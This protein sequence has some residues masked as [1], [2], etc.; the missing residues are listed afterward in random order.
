MLHYN[1]SWLGGSRPGPLQP[2]G[3]TG[4]GEQESRPWLG[5]A[6]MG[7]RH[8]QHCTSPLRVTCY[9]LPG[10][11]HVAC[12]VNTENKTIFTGKWAFIST[13]IHPEA[14]P[15]YALNKT[16]SDMHPNNNSDNVFIPM[17]TM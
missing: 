8:C 3:G 7:G 17:K 13:D 10:H 4:G 14:A 12:F 2:A 1:Q 15:T 16:Y 9:M 11:R 6:R 5:L